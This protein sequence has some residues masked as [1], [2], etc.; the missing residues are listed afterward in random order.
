MKLIL[1]VVVLSLFLSSCSSRKL[2]KDYK[3]IDASLEDVPDWVK[4]FDAYR[5]DLDKEDRENNRYYTFLTDPVAKRTL[6]CEWAR[7]EA[8][9][10]AAEQISQK[11]DKVFVQAMEGDPRLGQE[12]ALSQYLQNE[13]KKK[14]SQT[15]VGAQVVKTYWEKRG[16]KENSEDEEMN[17]VGYVCQV[18]VKLGV[19]DLERSK[20]Q[21]RKDLATRLKNESS[22]E[23]VKQLLD[24]V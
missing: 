3:V 5:A 19:K 11:I 13:L 2:V 22:K 15:L 18:L 21:V 7:S 8:S 4:D 24:E 9:A 17:K 20:E 12:D 16:Y 6:A 1:S 10:Y 14:V 23:R